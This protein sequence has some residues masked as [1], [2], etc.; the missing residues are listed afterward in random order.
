[1]GVRGCPWLFTSFSWLSVG[2]PWEL[3]SSKNKQI[4]LSVVSV[5]VVFCEEYI[6][7]NKHHCPRCPWTDGTMDLMFRGFV[8]GLFGKSVNL[9]LF[10][11]KVSLENLSF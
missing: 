3:F 5:G 10:G 6:K 1:V 4:P 7:K 9:K 2:C 11:L 8:R